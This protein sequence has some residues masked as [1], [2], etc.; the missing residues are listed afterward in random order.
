MH[1]KFIKNG[2]NHNDWSQITDLQVCHAF[3]A[4]SI[5]SFGVLFF[6]TLLWHREVDLK[7]WTVM[8]TNLMGQS[9]SATPPPP[10][11]LCEVWT[12]RS[13]LLM[14]NELL[15]WVCPSQ[16]LNYTLGWL[17]Y[18]FPEKLWGLLVGDNKKKVQDNAKDENHVCIADI[19]YT[20]L[21]MLSFCFY[22]HKLLICLYFHLTDESYFQE[23]GSS[24][25][26]SRLL[27]L[28]E[29]EEE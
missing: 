17:K 6:L 4:W 8:G 23:N 15:N 20:F 9:T 3:I 25:W 21:F 22:F 28:S 27:N 16:T 5:L 29:E 2:C 19:D 12:T 1:P 14:W 10:R 18:H 11:S 13:I 7:L 26:I 24:Y